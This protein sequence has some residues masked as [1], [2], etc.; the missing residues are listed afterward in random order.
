ML[1]GTAAQEMPLLNTAHFTLLNYKRV[2][3]D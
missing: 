2:K 3:E 1:P